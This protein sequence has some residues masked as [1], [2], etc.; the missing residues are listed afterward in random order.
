MITVAGVVYVVDPGSVNQNSSYNPCFG[1][2][3]LV[4]T[5]VS[6][7]CLPASFYSLNVPS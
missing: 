4:V 7:S 6:F 2:T 5:P 3:S 1:I